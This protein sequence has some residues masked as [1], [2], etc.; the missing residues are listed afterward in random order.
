MDLSNATDVLVQTLNVTLMFSVGLEVDAA[1]LRVAAKRWRLWLAAL[2][3]N[4]ACIPAIAWGASASLALPSAIGS[5]L[6]LAAC[7]PGGGTGTL[8]TRA[9]KGSMELS[10]VL[11]ALLTALAVPLTPLLAQSASSGDGGQLTVLPVLQTLVV[12]QLV[13][14]VA[15][16][17]IRARSER[18]A[19]QL[20]RVARP[21]SNLVFAVLVL[22]LLV[23]RGHLAVSIGWRGL[24]AMALS[25]VASLGLPLA[26]KLP[27]NERAALSMTT[28]VRNLSLALLLSSAFF[29]DATTIAVLA[30]GLVMYVFGAGGAWLMRRQTAPSPQTDS[31]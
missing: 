21:L 25:V 4:F 17:L 16:A 20:D 1:E 7:C 11:L 27:W 19:A 9:A 23:T 18:A 22:G 26:L 3:F 29:T 31:P 24:A 10:V 15:G 5:G 28:G 13:P 8:L 14:F 6:L 12:F 30:Y 2:A